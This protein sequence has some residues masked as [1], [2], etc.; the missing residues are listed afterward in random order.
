MQPQGHLEK[1]LE[2]QKIPFLRAIFDENDDENIQ[3]CPLSL[4]VH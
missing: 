3:V 1:N 4:P 2:K